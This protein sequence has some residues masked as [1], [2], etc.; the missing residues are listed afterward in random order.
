MELRQALRSYTKKDN[1]LA[2]LSLLSNLVIYF[3][4]VVASVLAVQQGNWLIA[5]LPIIVLAFAGVRLYV[6]QHDL[7]HLSL[8]ETRA[9][10]QFWG[11]LVSPFTFAAYPQMTY[12][13]NLHHAYV[14]DLDARET[15]EVYT[16]TV[17]EWAQAGVWKRLYYRLYRHP[18]VLIPVGSAFTY[19][20]AYRWPKNAAKVGTKAILAH[21]AAIVAFGLSLYLWAGWTGV[22]TVAFAIWLGGCIGVALVYLQHNFEG[23]WWD[24]R[25]DLD[26]ERAAIQGGSCLDFGWVFDEMVA[27]ITK[28]DIHHLVAAIPCYRLRAAHRELEKT[29]E[30]RRIS[31]GEA[32]HAFTLRLWDEDS[33]QLV[34]FP[35][36]R[37]LTAH[38]VGAE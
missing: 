23:T 28:H 30:L 33:E 24:R 36:A 10:N 3:G 13:H 38:E 22:L 17:R 5:P 16:M 20:I 8:F 29:H 26:M 19:F 14:G 35:K 2:Y 6:L 7:G 4:A 18:L 11:Y 37:Q 21:N 1:R 32:L 15:T 31:F 9:Q 34:P 27:N 12:N 25:P